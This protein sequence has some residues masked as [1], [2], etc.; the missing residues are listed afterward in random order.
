M[1]IRLGKEELRQLLLRTPEEN[2]PFNPTLPEHLNKNKRKRE[3]G[4]KIENGNEKEKET[5]GDAMEVEK[6]ESD[7]GESA[8]K[9]PKV[10]EELA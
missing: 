2:G 4:G 1:I 10:D 5:D 7:E 6:S 9:Y 8:A 3:K